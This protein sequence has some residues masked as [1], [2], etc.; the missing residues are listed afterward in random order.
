MYRT[1]YV[2]YVC[3]LL[4]TVGVGVDICITLLVV[5][6]TCVR[7]AGVAVMYRQGRR[8]MFGR[9]SEASQ[10]LLRCCDCT[11]EVVVVAVVSR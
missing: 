3:I 6:N 1:M 7:T 10:R 8:R 4:Y 5:S 2:V 9:T 11:V